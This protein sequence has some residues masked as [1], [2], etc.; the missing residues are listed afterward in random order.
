MKLPKFLESEDNKIIL[1]FSL[2]VIFI[3]NIP[4]LGLLFFG[5]AIWLGVRKSQ[6]KKAE[7]L[8][9]NKKEIE[10]YIENIKINKKLETIST[11]LFLE[12]NENAFLEDDVSISETRAVRYSTGSGAGVRVMKGVTVGGYSGKSSSTQEWTVI[13]HGTLTVTN[14]KLVFRGIKENRQIPINKIIGL[15]IVSDGISVASNKKTM[16][17]SVSQPVKW[18]VVLNIIRQV[19]NPLNFSEFENINIS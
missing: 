18:G 6:R 5:I 4:L 17:F 2:G 15:E 12:K 19:D 9:R 8:S 10:N 7:E 3:F 13:D 1:F 11:N 14:K 16:M